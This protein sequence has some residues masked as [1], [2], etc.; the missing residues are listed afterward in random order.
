MLFSRNRSQT[1]MQNSMISIPSKAISFNLDATI[2]NKLSG[3]M[4]ETFSESDV[5]LLYYD[6]I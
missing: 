1:A 3:N 2:R 4:L 5:K 6:P